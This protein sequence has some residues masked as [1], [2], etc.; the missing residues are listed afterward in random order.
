MKYVTWCSCDM[1]ECHKIHPNTNLYWAENQSWTFTETCYESDW[2][3]IW[4]LDS[5]TIPETNFNI[6]EK[7]EAEVNTLLTSWYWLDWESNPFV[8][9]SNYVFTDN[10]P[11]LEF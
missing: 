3:Y 1:I 4:F 6:V 11:I 9:V 7:T 8:S 5:E 2:T 10:R